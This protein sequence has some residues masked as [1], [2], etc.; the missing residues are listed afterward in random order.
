MMNSWV[1]KFAPRVESVDALAIKPRK[2]SRVDLTNL[3]DGR[4]R[5]VWGLWTQAAVA[6][7]V[8]IR[9]DLW[10]SL[11]TRSESEAICKWK[12][13]QENEGI[14]KQTLVGLNEQGCVALI[15]PN[16][17]V[18]YIA[19]YRRRHSRLCIKVTLYGRK[20]LRCSESDYSKGEHARLGR[21]LKVWKDE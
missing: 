14:H 10:N 3:R 18:K 12:Q 20:R 17:K 2:W 19:R 13:H 8:G 1:G 21:K 16:R 7:L 4:K 11:F 6:G 15:W 9:E 5:N